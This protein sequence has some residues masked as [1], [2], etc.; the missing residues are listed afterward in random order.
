MPS[1]CDNAMLFTPSQVLD[2]TRMCYELLGCQCLHKEGLIDMILC[3]LQAEVRHPALPWIKDD[4]GAA[5][6]AKT[7]V[8]AQCCAQ[9]RAQG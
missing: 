1:D 4:S 3:R 9:R 8:R 6:T 2:K 7:A 5:S